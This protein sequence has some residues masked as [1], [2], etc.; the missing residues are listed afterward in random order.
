M[1]VLD[2]TLNNLFDWLGCTYLW[3]VVDYNP[4]LPVTL[5]LILPVALTLI[6]PVVVVLILPVILPVALLFNQYSA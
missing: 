4:I 6:L 2:V 1:S 3:A 5:T